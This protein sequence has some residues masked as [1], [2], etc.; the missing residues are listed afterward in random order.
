MSAFCPVHNL[1]VFDTRAEAA[2]EV[3]R[4]KAQ[5]AI[6]GGPDPQIEAGRCRR[7]GHPNRW[8]VRNG[9]RHG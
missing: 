5:A 4:R 8:H 6:S 2:A 7:T 9:G 3:V 1:P